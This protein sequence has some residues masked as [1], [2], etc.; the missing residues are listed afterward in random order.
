[1]LSSFT[2]MYLKASKNLYSFVHGNSDLVLK[3]NIVKTKNTVIF[4]IGGTNP[5]QSGINFSSFGVKHPARTIPPL[6][7]ARHTP[8]NPYVLP[9]EGGPRGLV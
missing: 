1:M 8:P 4:P 5:I 9:L 7:L 2:I 3:G 6:L